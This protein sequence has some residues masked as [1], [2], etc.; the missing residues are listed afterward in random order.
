MINYSFKLDM[1][2]SWYLST[3]YMNFKYQK[4][5]FYNEKR[6]YSLLSI[7]LLKAKYFW[8]HVTLNM[9]KW[10]HIKPFL[11]IRI[12]IITA[13][14]MNGVT[15]IHSI[16]SRKYFQR[17]IRTF[18]ILEL[19]RTSQIQFLKHRIVRNNDFEPKELVMITSLNIPKCF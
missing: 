13:Q 18:C 17:L 15:I 14:K 16:A 12:H 10:Q 4:H 19:Y 5:T 1:I 3:K 8:K 9:V 6:L 11:Y 7:S 2:W